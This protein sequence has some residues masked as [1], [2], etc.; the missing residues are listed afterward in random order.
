MFKKFMAA[1]MSA[2]VL[3]TTYNVTTFADELSAIETE[4]DLLDATEVIDRSA[5]SNFQF[6][7]DV[8]GIANQPYLVAVNRAQCCVTVYGKDLQ[9]N[10]TVP[11][12][13]F[14]CSVGREGHA[15]PT[16]RFVTGSNRYE[17]RLMVDG[18]YGRYAIGV[19]KG[20]LF[21]SVPYFKNKN[22]G[23]LE[24]EEYNKLGNPASLGCIRLS[25]ADEYWIWT[26]C[27]VGFIA[28]IY[29]DAECPGPIGKPVPLKID[30]TNVETRGYD[31]TEDQLVAMQ[32]AQS[33]A[34][35]VNQVANA[36]GSTAS[37]EALLAQYYATLEA[38]KQAAKNQEALLAQ[39]YAALAAQAAG[40]EINVVGR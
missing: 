19:Y 34:A 31:P 4:A 16:G 21:H 26:N 2:V 6:K 36:V 23:S 33:V 15:T 14:V 25:V 30:V 5:Y 24:Y 20:I 39:Y 1:I 35:T 9:G 37:Q 13:A 29:D 27:P 10:Y 17:W 22:K 8:T 3:I 12:K 38:Q 32:N 28:V 11:V 7:W 40:N 18:T